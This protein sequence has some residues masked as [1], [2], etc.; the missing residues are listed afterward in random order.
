MAEES[1]PA[2]RR[3]EQVGTEQS[4][5]EQQWKPGGSPNQNKNCC[6]GPRSGLEKKEWLDV[7]GRGLLPRDQSR[8]GGVD[9]ENSRSDPN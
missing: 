1:R 2:Q 9:S 4:R 6:L 5:L 3:P 8:W 7:T